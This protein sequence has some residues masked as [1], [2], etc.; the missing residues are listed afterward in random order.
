MDNQF[1]MADVGAILYAS[2]GTCVV[3]I[4][5]LLNGEAGNTATTFEME[6]GLIFRF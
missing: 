5:Q 3:P 6:M 2:A 4:E 1:A